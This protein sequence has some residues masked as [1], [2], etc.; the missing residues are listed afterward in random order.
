MNFINT[1]KQLYT[2][3]RNENY[4]FQMHNYM[5][6]TFVFFGIR[7]TE[8]RFLLKT[9]IEENKDE[10]AKNYKQIA[11]DLYLL[12]EREFHMCAIEIIEKYSKLY[13]EEDIHLIKFLIINN[14]WWD[15]VDFI[16]KQILGKYLNQYPEN[17]KEVISQYSNSAIFGLLEV[18]YY[19]SL[20]INLKQMKS[21]YFISA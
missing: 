4:A 11:K 6:C 7:A 1:L 12:D 20:V 9:A 19:S 17:I 15:S 3:N 16:A 18:H 10:V 14:S 21:F 13:N 5:K 2:L 8:R